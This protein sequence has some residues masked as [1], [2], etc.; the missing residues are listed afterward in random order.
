[1]AVASRDL[2]LSVCRGGG[3]DGQRHADHG[4]AARGADDIDRAVDGGYPIAQARELTAFPGDGTAMAVV[5]DLHEEPGRVAPED[6][7][8]PGGAT[9]FG[10]VGQRLD[11]REVAGALSSRAE[12]WEDAVRY[13]SV[14]WPKPARSE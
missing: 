5:P 9:V 14:R 8:G 6:D 3:R 12:A 10:H 11:G 2:R 13:G 1:M 4:G 7:V